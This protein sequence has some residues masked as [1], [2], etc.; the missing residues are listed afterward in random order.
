MTMKVK[1]LLP[2]IQQDDNVVVFFYPDKNNITRSDSD[3]HS[4]Y[5]AVYHERLFPSR[6]DVDVSEF[7]ID[8]IEPDIYRYDIPFIAVYLK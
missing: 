4:H 8:F 3:I 6:K 7:E 5:R 2:L 1:E